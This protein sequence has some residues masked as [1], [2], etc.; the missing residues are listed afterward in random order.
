M[1]F[2]ANT[3]WDFLGG[4]KIAFIISGVL[5]LTSIVALII[6]GGPLYNIDFK[7]GQVV[8][9][10][11]GSPVDMGKVRSLVDAVGVKDVEIQSIG[12]GSVVLF[13]LPA[14]VELESGEDVADAV[15]DR[16]G[17]EFGESNID[18]RRQEIVGPKVSGELRKQALWA[19]LIALL[20]ILIYVSIRFKFRFGVAAV[21][22]LFHDVLITVGILT[23]FGREISLPVV[24]ALL[25]I[26][27]YSINDTIV[28]SDRIRENVR[29]LYREKFDDLTNRSLNQ[30]ISRTIITS[31]VVL[32]VLLC[33]F[34]FGGEVI[35]DF[36]LALIIGV[37]VGTYSSVY[38][39]SPIVVA[40]E[41]ASP[42]KVGGKR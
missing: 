34:F 28:I 2:L 39:V 35:H 11:F 4:R 38:V 29:I 5:I 15:I 32:L 1:Q 24:A 9:V 7:G 37:I 30:T 14:D 16:L 8:E 42:K 18:L 3:N 23:I 19:T 25:T 36:S 20:G 17:L 26:V 40:W 41:H 21:V 13:R 10:G 27:G 22:A 12:D 6:N 31:F 33:I